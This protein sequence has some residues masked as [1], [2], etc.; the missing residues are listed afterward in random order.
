MHK[1]LYEYVGEISTEIDRLIEELRTL[2]DAG[3]LPRPASARQ[4]STA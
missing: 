2:P 3:M 4:P 1:H